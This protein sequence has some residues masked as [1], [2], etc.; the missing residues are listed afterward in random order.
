MPKSTARPGQRRSPR[1]GSTFKRK[2]RPGWR[3]ELVWDGNRHLVS[4]STQQ[5]A[6]DRLDDLRR[7]LRRGMRPTATGT[8]AEYLVG[9]LEGQRGAVRPSTFRTT[10]GY[11]EN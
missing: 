2:D 7:E 5:E 6:R 3:G 1:E 9:W 10:A 4:G 8:V 11:V